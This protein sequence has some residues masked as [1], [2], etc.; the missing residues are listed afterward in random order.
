[1]LWALLLVAHGCLV[2]LT[3]PLPAGT[4]R[5]AVGAVSSAAFL[6][7]PP[8]RGTYT[9]ETRADGAVLV[10]NASEAQTTTLCVDGVRAARATS[11]SWDNVVGSVVPAVPFLVTAAVLLLLVV[12]GVMCVTLL[13]RVV[14]VLADAFFNAG[15]ELRAQLAARHCSCQPELQRLLQ[16][17]GFN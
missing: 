6:F 14:C 3:L 5:V 7:S 1:M 8:L 15:A 13:A 4:T 11:F 2:R 9:L 10:L 16:L 12:V 17:K